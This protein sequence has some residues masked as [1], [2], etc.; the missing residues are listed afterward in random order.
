MVVSPTAPEPAE[1][2]NTAITPSTPNINIIESATVA[3]LSIYGKTI[4]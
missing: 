3:S 2:T 4:W 1:K